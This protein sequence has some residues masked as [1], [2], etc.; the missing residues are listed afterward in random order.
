MYT[1]SF[2]VGAFFLL[3]AIVIFSSATRGRQYRAPKGLRAKVL[4]QH[5]V[6]LILVGS[7]LIATTAS[8]GTVYI[9]LSAQKYSETPR[10]FLNWLY[11]FFHSTMAVSFT[12]Y[13]MDFNG[14]FT[15][16]KWQFYLLFW[17]PYL[18]SEAIVILTPF[19]DWVFYLDEKLAYHRGPLMPL[20]YGLSA[21]Y[22]LLGFFFFIRYKK[23]I[24]DF[25]RKAI[26]ALIL[27]AVIGVFVQA[28]WPDVRVELFAEALAFFGLMVLLEDGGGEIDNLTRVFNRRA[29]IKVNRRLIETGQN[30]WMVLLRLR[31]LDLFSRFFSGMDMERIQMDVATYLEKLTDQESVFHFRRE[32]F[33]LVLPNAGPEDVKL[34]AES[35]MHRFR[36]SWRTDDVTATLEVVLCPIHVPDDI[37][38]LDEL[39]HL[40]TF[41]LQSEESGSVCLSREMISR[42]NRMAEVEDSL[43]RALE[44]RTAEVW[45]QP[46][47]SSE[48]G[49]VVS[50]EALS[51][52][53]D[54]KLGRISPEEFIPVAEQTGLI[55]ELGT[56]VLEESCRV[57]SQYGLAAL[58]VEY[59]ELNVSL[60][61][62]M[63]DDL[64]DV[65]D[66]IRKQYGIAPEQLNLEI[67]EGT[68]TVATDTIHN[69]MKTM[70]K[71]GYTFS[72]DDYGTG[73]SNLG[74]LMGSR[75]KTVKIDKSLLW[76][77]QQSESAEKLLSS[78]IGVLRSLNVNVVQEGVE[79]E[80]QLQL[81]RRYGGNLIQGFY[82]SRP[83]PEKEFVEYVRQQNGQE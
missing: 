73:A 47:V 71:K 83:L 48:T 57:M 61:Q 37:D 1:A 4:N 8:V 62:F 79:T 13:I 66:R 81:V 3:L 35:I 75:F 82:Y 36:Q 31:N 14:T 80:E 34:L 74:R 78:L 64:T 27:L 46:I 41:G 10:Y 16:R 26:P 22:I 25:N 28:I 52:L 18:I 20:L 69:M 32:D 55:W 39:D 5:F 9:E 51:R 21:I 6:F 23:A 30:Y 2:E 65:F 29:F 24:T 56:Y 40:L 19:T 49:K 50:A 76:N 43:R 44:K 11:F 68:S 77:A 54:E 67:T 12:L 45:Y 72:I 42:F 17:T 63:H 58:G 60:Y 15:G 33:A 59:M 38:S 7:A 53:S 70:N